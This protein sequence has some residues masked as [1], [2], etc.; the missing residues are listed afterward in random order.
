MPITKKKAMV[1]IDHDLIIRH[2]INGKAFERLNEEWDVTYVFNDDPTTEKKHIFTDVHDLGL[3]EVFTTHITRARMGSWYQ[4]YAISVLHHQ[5][6]TPNKKF[7]KRRIY[8]INGPLRANIYD[9]LSL[10]GIFPMVQKYYL[11]RQAYLPELE[12]LIKQKNPDI[13]I[14]PSV[15]TGYYMN[16][17]LVLKDRLKIPFLALMNSWD[18][19]SQKAMTTGHP[20]CLAVWGE[21]T[22]RQ[23]MTYMGM[24]KD[25][26]KILGAAQFQGYRNAVP[27]TD[28]ELR[29]MFKVPKGK[30]IILYA[31]VSKSVN[32][33]RHLDLLEENIGSG[34]IPDCHI[35]YRPHP[36]RGE[37][38][39]NEVG[40]FEKGYKHI[41]MDPFMEDYYRRATS[42][43]TRGI[44]MANYEVTRRLLGLVSGTISTLSTLLLETVLHG[45]P[46]IAFMP[47]A[48]MRYKFGAP[49]HLLPRLAHFSGLWNKPGVDMCQ[50]DDHLVESMNGLLKGAEDP[51]LRKTMLEYAQD[52][53]DLSGPTYS[54]RLNMLAHELTSNREA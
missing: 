11:N 5:R 29:E 9:A 8:E 6:G 54:E 51:E 42:E 53:V 44:D 15:L 4:L 7:R 23:A 31:G 10:P 16:E 19:P 20:D 17:L 46:T 37:L 36:W 28:A 43:T 25:K 3:K 24:P 35:L 30:P 39:N 21:E 40:F 26:V 34:K 12:E 1:F 38:V 32:E 52:F 18:N 45:K 33:T 50:S 41:S 27:E 2:F 48:D 13:L 49:K 47:E 22:R 14:Y